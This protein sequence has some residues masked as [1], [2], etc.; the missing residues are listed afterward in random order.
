MTKIFQDELNK[1]LW[2]A[3]DSSRGTVDSSIFKDYILSFLFYKYLSDQYKKEKDILKQRY[4]ENEEFF[5]IKLKKLSTS[6]FIFL[7]LKRETNEKHRR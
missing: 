2:A 1:I 5:K 3:A 7:S 4:G 6:W